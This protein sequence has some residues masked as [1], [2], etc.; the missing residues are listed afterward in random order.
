MSDVWQSVEFFVPGVPLSQGSK[1]PFG[2]EHHGAELK[3]WRRSVAMAAL[4]VRPEHWR[5]VLETRPPVRLTVVFALSR[6]ESHLTTKAVTVDGVERRAFAKS[7]PSRPIAKP[8]LDKLMRAIGDSLAAPKRPKGLPKSMPSSPG[9]LVHDDSEIVEAYPFKVYTQ[10]TPGAFI[11]VERLFV[12]NLPPAIESMI[13]RQGFDVY[14]ADV[15][16][17]GR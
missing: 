3:S 4:A 7:A 11:R 8:D 17:K 1:T 16:R 13:K 15:V 9:I 2:G 10:A 6:P 14:R 5:P 12:G